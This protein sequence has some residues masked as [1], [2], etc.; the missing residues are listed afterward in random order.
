MLCFETTLVEL[1]RPFMEKLNFNGISMMPVLQPGDEIIVKFRPNSSYERGD[2]LLVHE[3]NEWFAHRLITIDKVNTLKGD[4]SA[5]EEQ[6]NNRQIWGEV[7]GYKRGNQTVIWGNK[8]QPFKK[9]FA[10]LSAKNGLNLEIGTNNR[11]RRWI[12]LI[13]MLA[14]HRCEEIWL[15]IVNQKRSASSSS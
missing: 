4:R 12:C 14:L 13:L 1:I 15:K 11:W 6:I 7:I 10:W 5:T 2:I 9:L 3:N 8:G